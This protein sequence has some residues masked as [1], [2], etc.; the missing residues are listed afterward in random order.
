M[1]SNESKNSIQTKYKRKED[2]Q[3]VKALK[4]GRYLRNLKF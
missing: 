4:H 3:M 1:A 2:Y